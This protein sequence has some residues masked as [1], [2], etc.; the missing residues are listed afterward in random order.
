MM[1]IVSTREECV[2]VGIAIGVGLVALC[3]VAGLPEISAAAGPLGGHGP[4]VGVS[5]YYGG[6][7]FRASTAAES[8]ARGAAE[9]IRA[10]GEFNR[11]T[12]EAA[13]NMQ[14]A[15]SRAIVNAQDAVDAYFK[16][17]QMNRDYRQAE[18]RPRPT[19][20]DLER[21]AR[22]ARPDPL[23][24]SELDTLTGRVRWPILLRDDRFTPL[25][26]EME[27]LLDR[28]AVS[29]NLGQLDSFDAEQQLAVRRATGQMQEELREEI[30]NLPPQDYVAAQRFL[31]SLEYQVLH[32]PTSSVS[33]ADVR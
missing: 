10:R 6:Y 8:F 12:S 27:E 32:S 24:P 9:V 23:S 3:L 4:W 31:R 18:R 26:A 14:E 25:R 7:P 22:A 33:L 5:P 15:R 20:E 1:N 11:L 30:R 21:Y 16:I 19:R 2:P 28:W 13:I 17:R 29:R